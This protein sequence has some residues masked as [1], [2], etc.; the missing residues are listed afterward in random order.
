MWLAAK[1]LLRCIFFPPLDLVP[2]EH[3]IQ[4]GINN[5][6]SDVAM[7]FIQRTVGCAV[8][9]IR[10]MCVFGGLFWFAVFIPIFKPRISGEFGICTQPNLASNMFM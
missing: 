1:F 2:P 7:F 9:C 10:K 8:P 5:F 6:C 3:K 4:N